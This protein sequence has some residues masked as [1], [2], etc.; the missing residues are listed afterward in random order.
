MTIDNC[1][2]KIHVRERCVSMYHLNIVSCV[3]FPLTLAQL[4]EQ[5]HVHDREDGTL[6]PIRR[7]HRARG[8]T[9]P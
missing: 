3:P 2:F 8:I 9:N 4:G 1:A 7:I 6:L 5:Y